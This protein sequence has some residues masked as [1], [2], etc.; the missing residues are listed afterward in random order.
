MTEAVFRHGGTVIQFVGDE[1]IALYNAPFD[2][3]DHAVQAIGTGLEF[4]ERVRALSERWEGRCGA[5]I[6]SGVGIN[7]GEAV[8]GIIGSR[9]RVE[10]GALGDTINLGSRLEGLTKTF[11]T[12]IIVSESTYQAARDHFVGRFLGEVTVKGR[13]VPVRIYAI[14]GTGQ[15]RAARIALTL[16]LT[17]TN[18]GPDL[19]VSVQASLTDLSLT[20]LRAGGAP[21][22]FT[23]GDVVGLRFE[24]PCLPEAVVTEGRVMRIA[25][26]QVGIQFLE[27]SSENQERLGS[28]LRNQGGPVRS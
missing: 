20:G 5:P 4:Q 28:F 1:I 23:R 24:L 18:T 13:G 14:D 11:D 12:P 15:G 8:V 10:Y 27:L 26:G 9:Q 19:H 7:T 3:P 2:Q 6:R 16:P 21:R 17:I 22:D 25:D